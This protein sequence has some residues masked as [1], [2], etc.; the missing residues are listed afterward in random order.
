MLKTGGEHPSRFIVFVYF[1]T[2]TVVILVTSFLKCTINFMHLSR[3]YYYRKSL[4][5]TNGSGVVL[6]CPHMFL[7]FV[8]FL[9]KNIVF[10]ITIMGSRHIGNTISTPTHHNPGDSGF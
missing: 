3:K 5:L 1:S 8:L 9:S 10:L 6:A 2:T 7:C 4:P